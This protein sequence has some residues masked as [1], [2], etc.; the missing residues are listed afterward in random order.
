MLPVNPNGAENRPNFSTA[1]R[2]VKRYYTAYNG[3]VYA[4]DL[5]GIQYRFETVE[6][7]AHAVIENG[8]YTSRNGTTDTISKARCLIRLSIR[9][10]N[11]G[12]TKD[13]RFAGFEWRDHLTIR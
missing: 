11:K 9:A 6:T 2:F 13:S 4:T 12:V 3:E 1:R 5:D 8:Y 7:A 10:N